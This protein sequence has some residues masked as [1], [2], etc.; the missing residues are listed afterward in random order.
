METAEVRVNDV[1]RGGCG[2][3]NGLDSGRVDVVVD[4]RATRTQTDNCNGHG[5]HETTI[6]HSI[7]PSI[8]TWT[9][10]RYYH[11]H[12]QVITGQQATR[13]ACRTPETIQ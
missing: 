7:G 10:N 5:I 9:G 13:P 12:D 6:T 3:G 2:V 8:G 11:G 4:D 1:E